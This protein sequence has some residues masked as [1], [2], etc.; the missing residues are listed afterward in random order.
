VAGLSRDSAKAGPPGSDAARLSRAVARGDRDALAEFYGAWFDRCY[1]SARRLTGRDEAFC[2]DIVQDA[3]LR[4]VRSIRPMDSDGEL[5]AWMSAVVRSAA[6]DAI[7][8]DSRRAR[9]DR[10]A[11]VTP[12]SPSGAGT[13]V[14][15]E[16]SVAWARGAIEGLAADDRVLLTERFGRGRTLEAAGAAAG[17]S[18]GAAHGRLRR[19]LGRLRTLAKEVFDE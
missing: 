19:A 3:M 16:E 17:L 7:R 9:R 18:G 11:T 12:P 4:V 15:V 13:G 1:E 6:M 14:L 2:L 8:K 5:G 10:A